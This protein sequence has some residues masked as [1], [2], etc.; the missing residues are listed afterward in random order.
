MKLAIIFEK[1]PEVLV[2]GHSA[3]AT[4]LRVEK[5]TSRAEFSKYIF[6]PTKF[7]FRKV[8]RVTATILKYMKALNPLMQTEDKHRFKM[9]IAEKESSAQETKVKAESLF[10]FF[11]QNDQFMGILVQERFS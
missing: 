1:C 6:M 5:M 4:N 3:F 2:R 7:S 10:D 11:V 8:I 9:F